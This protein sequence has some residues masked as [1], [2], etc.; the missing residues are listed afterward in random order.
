MKKKTIT[1]KYDILS[2]CKEIIESNYNARVIANDLIKK[3]LDRVKSAT[4]CNIYQKLRENETLRRKKN[5]SGRKSIIV[6]ETKEA[7]LSLLKEDDTYINAE[8]SKLLK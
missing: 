4:V 6:D 7:I 8:I 2:W 3:N 1:N 5:G